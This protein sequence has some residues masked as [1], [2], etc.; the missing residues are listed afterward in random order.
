MTNEY[1]VNGHLLATLPPDIQRGFHRRWLTLN[2]IVK[3]APGEDL[4]AIVRVLN[5]PKDRTVLDKL[6]TTRCP[7]RSALCRCVLTAP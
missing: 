4:L 5:L 1:R 2:G 6:T 7:V 3:A